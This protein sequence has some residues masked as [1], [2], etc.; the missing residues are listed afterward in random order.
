MG[1]FIDLTGQTFGKLTVLEYVGL[2]KGSRT[3]W[4]CQCD[5]GNT[6][7][8]IAHSLRRGNTKSCG[9]VKKEK[10]RNMTTKHSMANTRFYKIWTGMKTR[11]SNKNTINYKDYGGR[12]ITICEEWLDFNNFKDDMYEDYLKHVE[13]FGEKQTTLDRIDVNSSYCI[14]NCKWSDYTEQANNRRIRKN[15]KWFKIISPD[16]ITYWCKNIS[17]F[18][19]KF[20]LSQ[21]MVYYCVSGVC[22]TH[23]GWKFEYINLDDNEE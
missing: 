3:S 22:K 4:L 19:R 23:K 12:G 8:T 18:C 17:C 15:A 5:C 9:C 13:E 20:K 11:C 16:N 2:S 1:N 21:R 7:I 10:I 6:T 14:E